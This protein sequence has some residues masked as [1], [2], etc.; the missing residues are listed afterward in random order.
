MRRFLGICLLVYASSAWPVEIQQGQQY[1]AGSLLESSAAGVALT[2]PDGWVAGWPQGSSMLV[3]A[4][5]DNQGSV[6]VYVDAFDAASAMQLMAQPVALGDGV[7]LVPKKAPRT[8]SGDRLVADYSVN[9]APQKLKARIET[10]IGGHGV[11]AAFI[12]VATPAVFDEVRGTAAGLADSM[13]FSAP[14]TASA[15]GS[16]GGDGGSWQDYM[17]GRYV[18]RYYTAS[19]YTEEEHVWLCSDGSFL[20]STASGGFGGGASGAFAGKGHG[21]WQAQGTT[22]RV[23]ELVLQYG[24]GSVSETGTT[25]GDWSEQGA[26]GERLVYALE[27]RD[28]KLYLDD[29]QWFR[30]ANQQCP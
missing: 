2:V 3:L 24:A 16:S 7:V 27:L 19:G 10:R 8:A 18:V 21:A 17:R 6:F 12:A 23:G 1:P 5:S 29:R 15:A 13:R 22:D 20:R 9:G 30:D 14:V 4:R 11:G 28:G 26:G 25:F